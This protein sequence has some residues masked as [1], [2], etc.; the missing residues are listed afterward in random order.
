MLEQRLR[1]ILLRDCERS[2]VKT[3]LEITDKLRK[4][5]KDVQINPLALREDRLELDA[6]ECRRII[7]LSLGTD[8]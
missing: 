7:D 1:E 6:D 3:I 8:N 4:E 5:G 2:P